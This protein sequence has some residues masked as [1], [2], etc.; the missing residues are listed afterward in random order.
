MEQVRLTQKK[1]CSRAMVFAVFGGLFFILLDLKPFGK[2]LIL[3]S[4]FSIINFILMGESITLKIGASKKRSAMLSL[5]TIFSRYVILA[6]PLI[7]SLKFKQFDFM[8]VVIGIFM[9]QIAI[10]S[11]PAFNLL[12]KFKS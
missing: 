3:G 2:G 4:I 12:S 6:I 7:I 11:E 1:Y 9:I 8:A 5:L 10:L